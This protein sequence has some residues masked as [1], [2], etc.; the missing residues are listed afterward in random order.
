[1]KFVK[2]IY[3]ER[4]YQMTILCDGEW[5]YRWL[6]YSDNCSHMYETTN[7]RS[8]LAFTI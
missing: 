3:I 6:W 1:M 5:R 2:L 8:L 4:R 7:V